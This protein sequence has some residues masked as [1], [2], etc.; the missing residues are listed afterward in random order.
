MLVVILWPSI[1]LALQASPSER[2]LRLAGSVFRAGVFRGW[3]VS[4]LARLFLQCVLK[5]PLKMDLLP[6]DGVLSQCSVVSV[7]EGKVY[8]ALST[9][10]V[11]SAL[12]CAAACCVV[13]PVLM[14]QLKPVAQW[15]SPAAQEED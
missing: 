2:M 10:V 15:C 8:W 1:L 7:S 9:L 4:V 11:L 14:V 6:L 3:C 12:S 13:Q 5:L